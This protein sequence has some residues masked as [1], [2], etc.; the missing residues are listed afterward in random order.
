MRIHSLV[1][2]L[3]FS[4]LLAVTSA[5]L[6][7]QVAYE[8][9][10]PWSQR[11][12]SGPDSE[13]P[14]W[15]YNL[16]ITGIRAELVADEPKAL[17][18]KHV[19]PRTPARKSIK[20][21]DLIIGA[22]GK[23]FKHAHRNGYGMEV[24]GA[25]G[26]VSELAEALENCQG[27]A[28]TGKLPLMVKRGDETINVDL[29]IGKEY[30]SYAATYPATCPK[31][32]KILKELLDYI[33]KQ[34]NEEGSFGDPVHNTFAALALLGSGEKR[35]LP[36]V[37]RNLRHL[38]AAIRSAD[39]ENRKYGLI[40]WTY[41]GTAIVLCEYYL[42]T[43][44]S[45]VLPELEKIRDLMEAGQYLD[46]SQINPRVKETHPD[47]YPQGPKQSHGGWGHNPGFEG[48]GPIAMITAQGALSF[49]L[50][51]RCGIKID[52]SRLDAA[53]AFLKRGTGKN[54]YLW[55][56]DSPGGGP[57][58]WADMGRTGAAGI[59]NFLSPYR[60]GDYA[61]Q[62]LRH[63]NVIGEHPQS[64]PDTHGSPP[65]GMAY[66]AL[67]AN[68]KPANFRKLMDANR[69]WFTM[70]QCADG[71]FYYQPN[72]DNAGY[73]SAARM[74]A[75]SVV[76]FIYTIPKQKLAITGKALP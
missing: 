71:T 10:Q 2:A 25:D 21:D 72:R 6:M 30:G 13:V 9:G 46:M 3:V 32:E 50:M 76:A 4:S 48:Y 35:Y 75:S 73:D 52:R 15:Y 59:A 53:F 58:D 64:F 70:A 39:D 74:T 43:K 24:F 23:R 60:D 68:I 38:C 31:S 7:G 14:G 33:S 1:P 63:S 65:M 29:E 28:A 49:S 22:N 42:I 18:V 56:G 41:M 47:S 55:Y 16:G 69:W 66:E 40:N 20:I 67:A 45:W 51:Q 19:F 34:Q 5:R 26:P 36:D 61:K 37:E 44:K 8:G 57:D 17:L 62:A 12:D 54:G 11:A 27:K